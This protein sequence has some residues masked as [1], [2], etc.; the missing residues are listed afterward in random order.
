MRE[1]RW[2]LTSEEREH[3]TGTTPVEPDMDVKT[4]MLAFVCLLLIC[5]FIL[6]ASLIARTRAGDGGAPPVFRPVPGA[7]DHDAPSTADREISS[8]PAP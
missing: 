7:A 1:D 3:L 5:I 6:A 4:S 2:G 8:A